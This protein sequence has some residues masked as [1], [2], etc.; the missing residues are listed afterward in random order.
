MSTATT[1]L[2]FDS[3]SDANFRAWGSGLAALWTTGGFWLQ[4]SDTGQINWSTVTAAAQNAYAGYEIYVV[5]DS[6]ASTFKIYMK[7]EYGSSNNATKGGLVRISFGTSTNGAGTLSGNVSSTYAFG[8]SAA[9]QGATLYPFYASGGTGRF[10]IFLWNAASGAQSG[11]LTIERSLDSSGSYTTS[12]FTW[13]LNNP[14]VGV[15]QRSM[16]NPS[17]GAFATEVTSNAFTLYYGPTTAAMGTFA[18]PFPVFPFLGFPDNPMTVVCG[19]K[20]G[21]ITE[22]ANF[23]VTF[24]GTSHNYLWSNRSGLAMGASLASLGTGIRYE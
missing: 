7:V 2:Q 21:D 23:N 13:F 4:A 9:G 20:S 19:M 17:S 8:G 5:N 11:V 3:T 24:Y 1:S 10:A 22:G 16:L 6:L 18:S 14:L 15:S 12:Y